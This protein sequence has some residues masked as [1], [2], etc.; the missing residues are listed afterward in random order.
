[1]SD[2]PKEIKEKMI[3]YRKRWDNTG[4]LSN[5]I[6]E[7]GDLVFSRSQNRYG[8][9]RSIVPPH[10]ANVLWLDKNVVETIYLSEINKVSGE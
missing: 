5:P 1:M 6:F 4:N 7:N 8:V 3:S 2:I 10:K 9:L